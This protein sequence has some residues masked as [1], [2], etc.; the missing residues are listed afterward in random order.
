MKSKFS[1]RKLF[2]NNKFILIL[3]VLISIVI[4]INMSLSSD[5]QS[6]A[7]ISNIPIDVSLSEDAKNNGLQIFSGLDQAASVTV[8][9]NRVALG[10]ID[11]NDI[12]VSA[13]TAGT[14]TAPGSYPLSLT[15]RKLNSGDNFEIISS[16]SPSVITVFFD[17]ERKSNFEVENKVNYSVADGYHADVT[18]NY[19]KVKIEGPQTEVS[20]IAS[21]CIEGDIGGELVKDT[22]LECDVKLYDADGNEIVSNMLTLSY[23][24][25]T[26]AFSVKP[27]KELPVEI[28]FVNKPKNLNVNAFATIEPTTVSIAGPAEVLDEID[29][30]KTEP[31]DF[32]ELNN[33]KISKTLDIVLP[34]GCINLSDS[35][36]KV[37]VNFDL[38][39]Y[40]TKKLNSTNLTVSGLNKKFNSEIITESIQVTI[41]GNKYELEKLKAKDIECVI[42]ASGIEGVT[43]SIFVPVNVKLKGFD[44]CWAYGEYKANIIV[45]NV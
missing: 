30:V 22:K 41:K 14:I 35:N 36:N 32:S 37:D 25:I 20:K 24:K 8:S 44:S 40:E 38:S 9:G 19:D 29:S 39:A 33:S 1:F 3:S 12:I 45:T 7:T 18:L 6:T 34:D 4:W 28:D 10:S 21:V 2:S 17:Y 42:D 5:N 26:V 11:T 43:G 27:I 23:D 16:V 31:V 13:P 15:A